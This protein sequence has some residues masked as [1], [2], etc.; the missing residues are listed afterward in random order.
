MHY[1]DDMSKI[2]LATFWVKCARI[3][4]NG[5]CVA[6]DESVSFAPFAYLCVYSM[7]LSRPSPDFVRICLQLNL[8]HLLLS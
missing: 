5:F 8:I 2:S 3:H 1:I 7:E 4:N 6:I